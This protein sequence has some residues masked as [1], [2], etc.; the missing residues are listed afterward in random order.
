MQKH[1]H[2]GMSPVEWENLQMILMDVWMDGWIDRLLLEASINTCDSKERGR[3]C[4][5]LLPVL[6]HEA[7]RSSHSSP[8]WSLSMAREGQ[9][10]R[11][12]HCRTC[13]SILKFY[14]TISCIVE[15]LKQVYGALCAV[16]AFFQKTRSLVGVWKQNLVGGWNIIT[17]PCCYVRSHCGL[18]G[19]W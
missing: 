18:S 10:G 1:S 4:S 2:G 13:S 15:R 9:I 12:R 16:G 8:F 11:A 19:A 14:S 3:H 17:I 5:L 7:L 6:F